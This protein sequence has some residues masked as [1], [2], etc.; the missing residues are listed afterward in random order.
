VDLERHRCE[1]TAL[2]APDN[3]HAWLA[4]AIENA[5]GTILVE[6]LSVDE[7]WL[8]GPT[9]VGSLISA[10]S[11]GVTVRLLMDSSWG[12]RDNPTVAKELNR[13]AQALGLD[14]EAKVISPY[15]GLSVMHNKGVIIDD[16]VIISSLN[17]GD[18]S[19]YQNREVG[20]A[21]SSPEVT[22]FF[23]SLF[24]QDWA[25]DPIPPT[26]D[27]PWTYLRVEAGVP[28]LL[29]GGSC[30][31]NAPG[32]HLE[33]DVGGDGSFEGNIIQPGR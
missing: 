7:D 33:W 9:L 8:D 24:W 30:T 19:L 26:I 13:Q 32:L 29:D 27:L 21:I 16:L 31:D 14:L 3:A 1:V 12:G 20:A 2:L 18:T 17:W 22:S 4:S 5:T 23:R 10:A 25:L 28:V 11:R 15:H 6:Q